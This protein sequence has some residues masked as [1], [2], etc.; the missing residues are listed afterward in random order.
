MRCCNSSDSLSREVKIALYAIL[1]DLWA[2]KR[3]FFAFC[4]HSRN[5]SAPCRNSY[6]VLLKSNGKGDK[7]LT[8][9]ENPPVKGWDG[10]NPAAG[11]RD[12]AASAMDA[13]ILLEIAGSERISGVRQR[14]EEY[15]RRLEK[16]GK[17]AK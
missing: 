14:G 12:M 16:V 8:K 6:E 7:I 5:S 1:R 2:P 17:N 13:F 11:K 3:I 9:E 10:E 15:C 4:V